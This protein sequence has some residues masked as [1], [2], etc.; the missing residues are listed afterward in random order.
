MSKTI[1]L[2]INTTLL[3]AI[4]VLAERTFRSRSEILRQAA[5]KELEQNGICPLENSRN[6]AAA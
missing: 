2:K 6:K 1:A 4:D 3:A 5:I